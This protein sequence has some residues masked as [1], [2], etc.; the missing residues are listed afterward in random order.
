VYSR[1]TG[2]GNSREG[3]GNQ[4]RVRLLQL[5]RVRSQPLGPALAPPAERRE[6]PAAAGALC[7]VCRGRRGRAECPAAVDLREVVPR[8]GAAELER[9]GAVGQDVSRLHGATIRGTSRGRTDGRTDGCKDKRT[10]ARINNTSGDDSLGT[11]RVRREAAWSI[12]AA[13]PSAY[14]TAFSYSSARA[15][16]RRMPASSDPAYVPALPAACRG[17]VPTCATR[18]APPGV[19]GARAGDKGG[20]GTR[21]QHRVLGDDAA[22]GGCGRT[23]SI[24][25]PPARPAVAPPAAPACPPATCLPLP[26]GASRSAAE[27]GRRGSAGGSP[28][29]RRSWAFSARSCATSARSCMMRRCCGSSCTTGLLQMLPARAAYCSVDSVSS[30]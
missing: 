7:R 28:C 5:L 11:V 15:P 10:D 2:R 1:D 24:S 21:R 13:Y 17:G 3:G 30:E 22:R 16:V 29:P 8:E 12:P 20:A 19:T 6:T 18:P 9:E 25:A 26:C 23:V 14:P 4:A 27:L